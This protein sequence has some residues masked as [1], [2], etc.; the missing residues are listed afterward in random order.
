MLMW[1][2]HLCS[3]CPPRNSNVRECNFEVQCGGV[4]PQLQTALPSFFSPSRIKQS[5]LFR[6]LGR[7]FLNDVYF[8]AKFCVL[9]LLATNAGTNIGSTSANTPM[10]S[11]KICIDE[12]HLVSHFQGVPQKCVAQNNCPHVHSV[13]QVPL[14]IFLLQ[15]SIF[16]TLPLCD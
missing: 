15:N 1:V 13:T 4:T 14:Y 5:N 16:I 10:T 11:Q 12:H 6:P 8:V 3:Q 7:C 2:I 9:M